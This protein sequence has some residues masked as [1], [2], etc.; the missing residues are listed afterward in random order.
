M[1]VVDALTGLLADVGDHAVALQTQLLG[2]LGDDG[3]D[4][5]HNGGVVLGHFGHGGDVGLGDDQ[6]MSGSLG[7]NVV[8]GETD[9]VLIDFIGRDL[10]FGDLAE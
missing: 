6:E 10:P 1:Q 7:V 3:E 5:G 2:D 9:L 4:V 8:K